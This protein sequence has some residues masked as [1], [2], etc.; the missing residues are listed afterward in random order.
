M[1]PSDL[2]PCSGSPGARAARPRRRAAA[3]LAAA[4]G[5]A[6]AACG[7]SFPAGEEP[8]LLRVPLGDSPTRGPA[9]AWVTVVEFADFQCPFCARAVPA[10][11]RLLADSPADVRLV[12]KHFPLSFHAWA[13]PAAIAAECARAQG[14]FWEMHDRIFAAQAALGAASAQGGAALAA[15]LEALARGAVA[16]PAAWQA[17][18]STATPASRVEGDRS[19]GSAL[20]VRGTPTFA[21]NGEA[22]VGAVPYEQLRGVVDAALARARASGVPRAEYYEQ[23]VLGR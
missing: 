1:P 20:G 21:V 15:A 9:D 7:G 16:D 6:V 19:L 10:V 23:V 11:E 2:A 17:C 3:V 4:L 22:L 8:A 13:R 12:F 5:F 18:L 14:A